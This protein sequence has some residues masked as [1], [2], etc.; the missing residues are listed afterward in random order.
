M[1]ATLTIVTL[2]ETV[3]AIA[4]ILKSADEIVEKIQPGKKVPTEQVD[5]L[6]AKVESLKESEQ[7][8]GQV[9]ATLRGYVR[10]YV[11]VSPIATK[12]ERL[13]VYLRENR[14][15]LGDAATEDAWSVV[16]FIFRD[17]DHDANRTY[18]TVTLDPSGSLHP[19]DLGSIRASVDK[20][21]TAANRAGPCIQNK[22][23]EDLMRYVEDMDEASRKIPNVLDQRISWV[24]ETLAKLG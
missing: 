10:S 19:E 17:I 1:A 8:I 18:R 20:F 14:G 13:L 7:R 23:I 15:R 22:W 21:M 6:K 24:L 3:K 16:Y 11:D 4:D 2:V 9:A 5:E 12:C